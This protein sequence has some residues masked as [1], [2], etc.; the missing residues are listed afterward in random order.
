MEYMET[1]NALLNDMHLWSP[2]TW[3]QILVVNSLILGFG[4]N[5]YISLSSNLFI[6]K[7]DFIMITTELDY[8][9]T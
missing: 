3:F 7:K 6:C 9:I 8:S 4:I 5:F 2:E 1:I